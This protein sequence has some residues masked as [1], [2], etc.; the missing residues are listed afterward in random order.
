MLIRTF[1]GAL[2]LAGLADVQENP[3]PTIQFKKFYEVQ[4]GINL[5]GHIT[6]ALITIVWGAMEGDDQETLCAVLT[7][8]ASFLIPL[9]AVLLLV[10]FVPAFLAVA[11]ASR[12]IAERFASAAGFF[13]GVNVGG[14]PPTSRASLEQR[15]KEKRKPARRAQREAFKPPP[16]RPRA[17]SSPARVRGRP[18]CAGGRRGRGGCRR[19][20][21]LPRAGR[22][23]P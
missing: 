2:T 17:R 14:W 12:S 21:A 5:T 13:A 23:R 6:D 18:S 9:V 10:T 1:G 22:R 3:L 16:E 8:G 20:R 19:V 4:S 7:D 15:Q 11:A